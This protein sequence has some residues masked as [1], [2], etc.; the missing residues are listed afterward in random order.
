MARELDVWRR[1]RHP[2]VQSLVG[3]Y[4]DEASWTSF[5]IVTPWQANGNVLQY[6]VKTKPDKRRRRKLVCFCAQLSSS[7]VFIS[8]FALKGI[9]HSPWTRI[10]TSPV[11][12]PRR[13]QGGERITSHR[14]H[15]SDVNGLQENTLINDQSHAVLSDFC[16]AKVLE[17][18]PGGLKNTVASSESLRYSAPELSAQEYTV[19]T[20]ATDIWSWGCLLLVVSIL[21]T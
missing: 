20:P 21:M 1:F 12:L 17:D 19:H 8:D 15:R 9:G 2:N 13:Y 10:P 14:V 7:L 11:R 18:A 5:C 4:Y 16:F 6:L 3:F